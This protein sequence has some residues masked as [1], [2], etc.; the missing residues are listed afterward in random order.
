[1]RKFNGQGRSNCRKEKKR[2]E[3]KTSTLQLNGREDLIT[4]GQKRSVENSFCGQISKNTVR[5]SVLRQFR[6]ELTF[7]VNLQIFFYFRELVFFITPKELSEV[8][9]KLHCSSVR[10]SQN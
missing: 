9:E 10:L 3:G 6:L 8:Y 1:M 5:I 4:V 7:S 2:V